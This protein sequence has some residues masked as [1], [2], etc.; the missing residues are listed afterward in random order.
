MLKEMKSKRSPM[1]KIRICLKKMFLLQK[2]QIMKKYR[3]NQNLKTKKILECKF[4]VQMVLF[5]IV[6][7]TSVN[8]S[9]IAQ[10]IAHMRMN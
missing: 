9:M 7:K 8:V 6:M 3:I 5:I 4:I 1:D 2:W 10:S